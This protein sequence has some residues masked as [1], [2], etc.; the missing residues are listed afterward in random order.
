[1]RREIRDAVAEALGPDFQVI[2]ERL[3]ERGEHLHIGF[4]PKAHS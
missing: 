3:G 1:M 2:L 4:R